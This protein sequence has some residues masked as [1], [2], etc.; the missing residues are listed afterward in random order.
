[1]SIGAAYGL[2]VAVFQWGWG[3]ALI[4]IHEPAP[5]MSVVPMFL[6]AVLF[7]LSMDYEVFL[8]SR[9]REDYLATGDPHPS[10]EIH[11]AAHNGR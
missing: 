10:A 6:F 7:G 9:V 11:N 1:V 2:I 3:L 5:I 4:G 8:M